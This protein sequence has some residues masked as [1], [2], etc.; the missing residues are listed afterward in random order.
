MDYVKVTDT[1]QFHHSERHFDPVHLVLKQLEREFVAVTSWSQQNKEG[2]TQQ[3]KTTT[4]HI[5]LMRFEGFTRHAQ[6]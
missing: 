3:R 2:Q 1:S 6:T 5:V 4:L